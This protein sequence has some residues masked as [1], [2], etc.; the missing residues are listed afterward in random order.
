M[1]A[2]F[3]IAAE[4]DEQYEQEVHPK[5]KKFWKDLPKNPTHSLGKHPVFTLEGEG[6]D[7]ASF[8]HTRD[9]AEKAQ[10]NH[11]QLGQLF[12]QAMQ[13]EGAH[14]ADLEKL[15]VQAVAKMMHVK[16]DELEA[17]LGQ[18]V[19][20]NETVGLSEE[21]VK[22]FPK[23]LI[24]EAK[25][26]PKHLIDEANKRITSNAFAQGA[27]VH[28]YLTAH[29]FDEIEKKIKEI[30]PEL[31]AIY[32]KLASG[33]HHMYWLM[34]M[35]KMNLAGA[36]IGSVKPEYKPDGELKAVAK[37]PMFIVLVQEL[38]KGVMELRYIK[39]LQKSELSDDEIRSIYQYADKI[40]DE[41][42]LIQVG[43]E[44][45]RRFLKVVAAS[46]VKQ[47][48]TQVYE[49][50]IHLDPK[51]IH[52]FVNLVVSK[53]AD[54]SEKLKLL[55]ENKA[56]EVLEEESEEEEEDHADDWKKGK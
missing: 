33:S 7:K 44:L 41:P 22:E 50:L 25:E 37:S 19:D 43:P 26:F 1:K 47:N 10:V 56:E 48:S 32:A 16:E 9:K 15:A 42:R 13:H 31:V 21:E 49:H 4:G 8:K 30:D 45:W 17:H 39:N 29:F 5:N 27:S 18:D 40:E 55:L 23:H 51:E 6:L 11:A 2:K 12:M 20:I 34:N 28:A 3:F 24:D 52:D 53:P 35:S 38:V 46:K 54:A 14:K 36:A